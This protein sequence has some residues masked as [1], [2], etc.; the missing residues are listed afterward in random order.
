[1]DFLKTSLT[2]YF[3]NIPLKT[4][5]VKNGNTQYSERLLIKHLENLFNISGISYTK[6]GTQ[7]GKDFRNINQSTKN[8]EVKILTGKFQI[9]FNDTIPAKDTDYLIFFT[10]IKTSKKLINPKILYING[11]EFIKD[12]QEWIEEV[13][14]ILNTLKDKY[15]R[16]NNKKELPGLM[17]CYFRPTWSSNISTF[18]NNSEY[19]IYEEIEQSD[20]QCKQLDQVVQHSQFE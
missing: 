16:G 5:T 19:I 6:A 12:S 17:N 20:Q 1:M 8:L 7:Q 10:G 13:Q 4:F 9:I 11:S 2:N 3:R 18:I 15:C 14:I